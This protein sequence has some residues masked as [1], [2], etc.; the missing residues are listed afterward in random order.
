MKIPV[1]IS[2]RHLH[3]S[4]SVFAQLF[5]P[6]AT[7]TLRR[8]LRQPGEFAAEETVT[9]RSGD[10]QIERVR[11]IG[12]L[13]AYSQVEILPSDAQFLGLTTPL[14]DSGDLANSASLTLIGPAGQVTLDNVCIIANRHL[15][16]TPE[17]A[18][19]IGV[20]TGDLVKVKNGDTI[21]DQVHLKIAPT[22]ANECHLDKDDEK[23]FAIHT[24]DEVEICQ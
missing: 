22:Y 21:I 24:G 18:T 11:L 10:K 20:T 2:N 1:G 23:K 4:A 12:P 9:L 7:P 17:S 3:L 19:A 16:L 15:H 13:R 6:T 8:A 14:R 5:G